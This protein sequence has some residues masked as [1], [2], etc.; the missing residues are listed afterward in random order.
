[1]VKNMLM[2]GLENAEGLSRSLRLKEAKFVF[3]KGRIS[4]ERA[5]DD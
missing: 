2:L 1:M 4:A 5:T 3:D